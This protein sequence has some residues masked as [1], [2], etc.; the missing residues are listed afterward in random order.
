MW[1]FA[2]TGYGVRSRKQKIKLITDLLLT[3]VPYTKQ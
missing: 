3:V 1:L 2:T